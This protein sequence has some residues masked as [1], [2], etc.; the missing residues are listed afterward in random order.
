MSNLDKD[1]LVLELL[2]HIF[3]ATFITFIKHFLSNL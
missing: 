3:K 2:I 1:N